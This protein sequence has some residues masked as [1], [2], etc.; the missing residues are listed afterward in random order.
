MQLLDIN[1]IYYGLHGLTKNDL[2]CGHLPWNLLLSPLGSDN[3]VFVVTADLV[4]ETAIYTL[5]SNS[6]SQNFPKRI[7]N[8][9]RQLKMYINAFQQKESNKVMLD[10]I[11]HKTINQPNNYVN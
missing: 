3:F 5:Q 7:E 2:C 6:V 10:E 1:N 9:N 11:H 8:K 4:T